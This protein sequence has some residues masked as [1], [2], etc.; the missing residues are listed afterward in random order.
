MEAGRPRWWQRSMLPSHLVT[1]VPEDELVPLAEAREALGFR[2]RFLLNSMVFVG[3]LDR[4]AT[5]PGPWSTAASASPPA[6]WRG[7]WSGG[8][9]PPPPSAA[10]GS[11]A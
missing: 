3:D 1:I 2:T 4:A 7:R 6:R 8:R 5:H 11:G 9:A 10:A